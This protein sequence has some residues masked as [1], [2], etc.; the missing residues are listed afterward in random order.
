M[1]I[2]Y[3]IKHRA[4]SKWPRWSRGSSIVQEGMDTI[5]QRINNKQNTTHRSGWQHN[6]IQLQFNTEDRY[7][8]HSIWCLG[9]NVIGSEVVI[10]RDDVQQTHP[11]EVKIGSFIHSNWGSFIQ[12]NSFKSGVHSKSDSVKGLCSS[13]GYCR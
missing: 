11:N 9:G 6:I 4:D 13:A 3:I 7:Q 2:N 10:R 8:A 1:E 5:L 12:S